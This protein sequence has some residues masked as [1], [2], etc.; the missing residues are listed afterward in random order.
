MLIIISCNPTFTAEISEAGIS[1]RKPVNVF[2]YTLGELTL[3]DAGPGPSAAG[4]WWTGSD[5]V[6]F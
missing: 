1:K 4:L 3:D 5:V 2:S 6:A